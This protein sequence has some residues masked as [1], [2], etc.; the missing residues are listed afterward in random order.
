MLHCCAV[1]ILSERDENPIAEG[2][3][4]VVIF[5]VAKQLLNYRDLDEDEAFALLSDLNETALPPLPEREL[6][7]IFRSAIRGQYTSTGCDDPLFLPYADPAC[8]IAFTQS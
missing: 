3:R 6:R 2:G 8:P 7:R 5:N 1:K 4:S